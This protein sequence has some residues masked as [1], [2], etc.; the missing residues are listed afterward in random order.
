MFGLKNSNSIKS[1]LCIGAHPDD[2]ELGC[3]GTLIKINDKDPE[4]IIRFVIVTNG[5]KTDDVYQRMDE[6]KN[7]IASFE[8]VQHRLHNDYE[9]ANINYN[10]LVDDL[11]IA[12]IETNPDI[13]FS[14]NPYDPHHDHTAV[15]LATREASRKSKAILL[16]YE[17]TTTSNAF[18]PN[19]FIDI[20]EQIDDK[21]IILTR[22][23]SQM[24][25]DRIILDDVRNLAR[26][27]GINNFSNRYFEAFQLVK[28]FY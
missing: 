4:C 3:G 20:T 26:Y 21:V 18:S 19:V 24:E 27:R 5:G 8:A 22:F 14:H 16:N 17:M 28:S 6:Q 12:I 25:K 10:R 7:S 15:S 1:V 9:D 2:I 23:K 11:E 13:I